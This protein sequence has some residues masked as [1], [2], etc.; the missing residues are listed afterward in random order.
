MNHHM[1]KKAQPDIR[2]RFTYKNRCLATDVSPVTVLHKA[3]KQQP[4]NDDNKKRG[5]CFEIGIAVKWRIFC[6]CDSISYICEQIYILI[7]NFPVLC[8]IKIC[9]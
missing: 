3:S 4:E 1:R 2:D 8:N 9:Q 6:N 5:S 7:K